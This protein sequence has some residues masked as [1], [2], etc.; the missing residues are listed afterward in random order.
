ML[1]QLSLVLV[2]SEL[3]ARQSQIKNKA[4][5]FFKMLNKMALVYKFL[6]PKIYLG[7]RQYTSVPHPS[8]IY[9]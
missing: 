7:S 8:I 5:F 3:C 9:L 4:S 6:W 1:Y 2:S